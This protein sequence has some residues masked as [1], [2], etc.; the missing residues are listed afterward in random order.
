MITSIANPKVK[1]VRALQTKR[2][3][4][5]E[6]AVFVVEGVR[7][8]REAVLA[9][10]QARLVLHTEAI[11]PRGRGV[12]NQLARL[13]A[14]V[15]VVSE[16][17]MAACSSA[18]TPPGILAVLGIP[19]L[20]PPQPVTLIVVAD[21][22][23]D[24]GNLG[25]LLR[26]AAA[27]GVEAVITTP[28]TVDAYNPKVVR[29]AMGAHFRLPILTWDEERLERG[30]AGLQVWVAEPGKGE[31]Y[32]T[33]DWRQPAALVIGGEVHGPGRVPVLESARRVHVPMLGA[34]ES[35]NAS[36][37]AAVVLCEI[38]RQRGPR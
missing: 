21:G 11:D 34:T 1:W 15:D 4:R 35:L 2:K 27:T 12:V 3:A 28:G 17:V 33:P 30:L 38:A 6:E 31:K 25:T 37:A 23:A 19:D 26:T 13:G 32:Y 7:L 8:A 18:E 29:G 36:I 5:S 22:L 14:E 16:A 24:P 10:W 9:E 20:R